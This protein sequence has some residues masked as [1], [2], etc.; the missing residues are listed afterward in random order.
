MKTC[1][2]LLLLA[3]SLLHAQTSHPPTPKAPQKYRFRFSLLSGY[4]QENFRWSI[5]G[6]SSGTNPDIYSELIWKNLSGPLAGAELEFNVWRS[7]WIRSSISR[8][9]FVSGKVTDM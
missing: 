7:F 8:L 1:P 3:S 6:N 2:L 9:F 4:Q 5:A